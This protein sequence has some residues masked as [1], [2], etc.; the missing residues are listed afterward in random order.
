MSLAII[1]SSAFGMQIDVFDDEGSAVEEKTPEQ[2]QQQ[3]QQKKKKKHG[4]AGGKYKMSFTRLVRIVVPFWAGLAA[5]SPLWEIDV[6]KD[7]TFAHLSSPSLS[8]PFPPARP[9]LPLVP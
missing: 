5:F 7:L 1:T 9:T 4:A 8:F 6:E 2:E 3:Q